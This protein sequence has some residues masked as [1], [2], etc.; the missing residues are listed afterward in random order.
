MREPC[1]MDERRL[2]DPGTGQDPPASPWDAG[3]SH[4]IAL[5]EL[6]RSPLDEPRR[7]RGAPGRGFGI[8]LVIFLVAAAVGAAADV[9]RN[10]VNP[11]VDV[12]PLSPAARSTL[13]SVTPPPVPKRTLPGVMAVPLG[14]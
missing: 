4:E 5:R 6:L 11:G 8:A 7:R 3:G 9:P 14:L 12:E 1:S 10:A 13:L 2:P